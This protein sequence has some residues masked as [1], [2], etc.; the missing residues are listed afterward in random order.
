[1]GGAQ[2]EPVSM[3][4]Q[5][6]LR[7]YDRIIDAYHDLHAQKN[8]LIKLYLAFVS[9]PLTVIVIFLALFSYFHEQIQTEGLLQAIEVAAVYFSVLLIAVS[10]CVLMTMLRIRTEQYLYVKT[11]NQA[12]CYFRKEHKIPEEYLVLPSC[13]KMIDFSSR[14]VT[15]RAF[16]EAMVIACTNS[17]LFVFLAG[18]FAYHLGCARACIWLVSGLVLVLGVCIHVGIIRRELREGLR[19]LQLEDRVSS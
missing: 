5:F 10:I 2:G 14:E 9:L 1:M 19:T 8:E 7:E 13:G 15:G 17:L 11:I 3:A 4:A 12:R 18:S 6:M 16:W